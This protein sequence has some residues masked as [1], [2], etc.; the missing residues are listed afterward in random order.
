VAADIE[1]GKTVDFND[2]LSGLLQLTYYFDITLDKEER[3]RREK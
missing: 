1:Y 2:R 3:T